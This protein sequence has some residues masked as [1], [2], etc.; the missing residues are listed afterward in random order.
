MKNFTVGDRVKLIAGWTSG[1]A[2]SDYLIRNS[3][4]RNR[5]TVRRI[6]ESGEVNVL[7]DGPV[8][9]SAR[10]YNFE[11]ERLEMLL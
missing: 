1:T 8:Q 6:N 10:I 11:P 2:D 3:G 5:F 9:K 4:G 7:Q